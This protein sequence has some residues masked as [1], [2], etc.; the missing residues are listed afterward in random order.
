MPISFDQQTK[1]VHLYN[2]SLSYL[3]TLL[4]TGAVGQVYCGAPLA[5]RSYPFL[6]LSAS[7]GVF[8]P[9]K[10]T[11]R[12]EYPAYGTG[13]YRTPAFVI[14]SRNGSTVTEPLY[15]SHK[16]YD[17]KPSVSA[18][19]A[20]YTEREDEAQTVELTLFD[21]PSGVRIILYYTIFTDLP[22]IARRARFINAGEEPCRVRKAMSLN[23]DL[24]DR[25]WHLLT[26]S[27]AWARELQISEKPLMPG[28]QGIKSSRGNS[29]H[30]QNPFLILKRPAT[31][32]SGGEAWGFSLLYSGNFSATVESDC[33]GTSRVQLGINDETFSWKLEKGESFDT[34]EAVLV[35]SP[36]GLNRLS[37]VFHTVYQS[38]LARGPWRDKERPVLLNNWEGTYFNFTEH[39]LLAMASAAKELGIELFVLDDGWFGERDNDS[40]SLGDWFADTRKLPSG[41]AG[42]AEQITGMGLQFGL[43]IEPEMI[44][45]KSRLFELHP[46][47]AIGVPGR[48]RSEQRNQY[49]LDMS[50]QEI[51]DYLTTIITDLIE[52][53]PISYI[54]WDMNRSITE[55]FSLS[56]P[57][58]RQGEF[59][60]RYIL[61]VYELYDR[62]TTRFPQ[63][64]FE[65]CAGGGGRF[66]PGILAFAPQAWLS[67]NTDALE[68]LRLQASASLVYPQS[69]WGSHVSAVPNHQTG[70]ST[71][72]NFRAM[73]AFF[74]NLGFELD[75][76][77][78]SPEEKQAIASV[79]AFYKAHRRTFQYGRFF[80]LAVPDPALYAAWQVSSEAETLVG[81]YKLLAQPNR[82]PV[83]LHLAGLEPALVYDV[84]LWEEGGFEEQ[85]KSY[86]CGQRG[87]DELM[88]G[89]LLL[90]ATYVT[91]RGDFFGELFVIRHGTATL[92]EEE[93]K[94]ADRAGD[95]R[96]D[97]GKKLSV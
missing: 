45:K 94:P 71:S 81:F 43:W 91:K 5:P 18:L 29:G 86:N 55:P 93:R 85:D 59:F 34:P 63:V 20:L 67:D 48:C 35:Y 60:H 92:P 51:V 31:T 84:S 21:A 95:S 77:T 4:Y 79:C 26:V 87:G 14:Q 28:F 49:V 17:G 32:D 74:G 19:P 36:D 47:W 38:R 90:D 9:D 72:L 65:S 10:N 37:Q 78:L 25:D 15:Q 41:I 89:G 3:F 88:Y 82:P 6:A 76:T 96:G 30:Q 64:L 56:L 24:P 52:S 23:L 62:L 2:S 57:P 22:V 27:G 40:S 58:D 7:G 12:F 53:A 80:R 8:H 11:V 54:K 69:S 50:R 33:Y 39:K 68:R 16:I 70:R 83:R 44:S 66:D 61:G 13:D 42:L 46:D 73:V 1:T 97:F 75:P